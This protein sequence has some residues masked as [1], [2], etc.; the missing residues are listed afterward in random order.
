MTGTTIVIVGYNSAVVLAAQAAHLPDVPV[1][2]V[3]NGSS[4]ETARAAA[5]R[6]HRVLPLDRNIGFGQGAMVGISAAETSLVLVLNPDARIDTDSLAAL[7][8]A[9]AQY[10]NSDVFVPQILD[11]TGSTFFRHECLHEPRVRDRRPPSGDCCIRA[12]SGAAML[13]RREAFLAFGGF[14]PEIFLFFEDDDIAIR[15]WRARRPAIHVHDARA[16]HAGDSSSA[17][18]SSAHRIKDI[19]FGWSRLYLGAKHFGRSGWLD[20]MALL[21]KVPVYAISGRTRRLRRQI[22]RIRG[23]WAWICGKPAPFRP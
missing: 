9:A 15:C 1:I 7:E 11:E 2:V 3:D 19:S 12:L 8:R 18:D 21:S 16:I 13:L 10:P 22:G 20:L 5:V 23:A 14:D 17:G 6:G 4:D